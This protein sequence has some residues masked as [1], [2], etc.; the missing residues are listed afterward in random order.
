MTLRPKVVTRRS[1][2]P[3]PPRI[4]AWDVE[5]APNE[6]RAHS[7]FNDRGLPA[8]SIR[9]EKY[10][11][12]GS[13]QVLG[14]KSVGSVCVSPSKPRDDKKVVKE[15]HRVL[16]SADAVIAHY[17]N[18][19]DLP[20]FNTR[21]AYYGLRPVP[22]V[23]QFDTYKMAK[24]RFKFNANRLDYLGHYLGLGR[25]IST[26]YALWDGCMDGDP[27]SL[28]DMVKY[29][30]QDV[31]LL[32]AVFRRLYPYVRAQLDVGAAFGAANKWERCPHCGSPDM[33]LVGDQLL[34]TRFHLMYQCRP[35][36]AWAVGPAVNNKVK[37][38][39]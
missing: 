38:A 6:V 24:A 9:K 30:A 22:P 27:K 5:T 29:N 28:R 16:T 18:W 21:A 11:I 33:H 3:R 2:A 14:E 1:F 26:N 25:K 32:V 15:L 35:C 36:G 17:G 34:K 10:I 8:T 23:V 20:T 12:C 13:W 19:F 4:I 7:L 31:R 39:A 37:H